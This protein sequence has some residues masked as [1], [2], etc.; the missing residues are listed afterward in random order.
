VKSQKIA[1]GNQLSSYGG[2]RETGSAPEGGKQEA[3]LF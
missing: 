3:P 2:S 1:Y